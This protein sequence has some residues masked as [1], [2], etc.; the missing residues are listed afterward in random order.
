MPSHTLDTVKIGDPAWIFDVNR[1]VYRKGPDGKSLGGGPVWREHWIKREV[2]AETSRSWIIGPEYAMTKVPKK[3]PVPPDV[4]FSEEEIDRQAFIQENG[5]RIGERV[6]R[7][8]DYT[9]L[10]QIA[11]LI[12]YE[13]R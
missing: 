9:K 13:P 5:Y 1:R 7:L 12:G 4:C 8:N 2:T 3:G 6:G 10:K 11:E